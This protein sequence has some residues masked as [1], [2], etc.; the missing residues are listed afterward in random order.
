MNYGSGKIILI[1]AE[2]EVLDVTDLSSAYTQHSVICAQST[3]YFKQYFVLYKLNLFKKRNLY[4]L[5]E[6]LFY[7]HLKQYLNIVA[8]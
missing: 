3:Q 6:C 8:Q 5:A 2:T 1:K 7:I 4:F